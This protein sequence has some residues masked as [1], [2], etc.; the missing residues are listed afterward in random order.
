MTRPRLTLAAL[1]TA[2]LTTGMAPGARCAAPGS[3][4]TTGPYH[5]PRGFTADVVTIECDDGYKLA[6][7]WLR[8][9]R[10][11][12]KM[13]GIIFLHE[14]GRDRHAWY[15]MTIMTAGRGMAVLAV[16]LR[17][18]GE[19]PSAAGN[20]PVKAADL[21]ASDYQAM[22]DDVRNAV[23]YLA[24]RSEVDGGRLAIVG[25]GLGANLALMAAGASWAEAVTCVIAVSPTLDDHGLAP[26]EAVKKIGK[27]KTVY[28]AAAQDDPP[29]LAACDAFA[30]LL[31]HVKEYFRP[32]TGGHGLAL[33]G[34]GL[35]R[36]IPEW[37]HESVL[38]PSLA[39]Q[40]VLP[41]GA[42]ARK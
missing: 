31:K 27:S 3:P 19:N 9:G 40:G 39:A 14:G 2:V 11:T 25:S 12:R 36:K 18:H 8:R 26:L 4:G 22:L 37:L 34:K 15:P 5:I 10:M 23:S 32:E 42:P 6:A 21:S 29:A 41:S 17:G 20:A 7:D 35:F 30:P 24:I 28:L 1:L 16:D 38:A 13:P 33:F